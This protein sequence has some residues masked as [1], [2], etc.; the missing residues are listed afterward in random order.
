MSFRRLIYLW[1]NMRQRTDTVRGK[2][3]RSGKKKGSFYVMS[4]GNEDK[5]SCAVIIGHL[6]LQR[7]RVSYFRGMF[8]QGRNLFLLFSV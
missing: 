5:S 3:S 2:L 1:Q 4:F 8:S 7:V 6:L